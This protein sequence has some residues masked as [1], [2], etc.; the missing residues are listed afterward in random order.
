MISR[1]EG[2]INDIALDLA[3][4]LLFF[5][6]FSIVEDNYVDFAIN[7]GEY[8]N[9]RVRDNPEDFPSIWQKRQ[10]TVIKR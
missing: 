2:K 1:E 5:D 8:W 10:K 6:L 3:M 7:L 4:T 9:G